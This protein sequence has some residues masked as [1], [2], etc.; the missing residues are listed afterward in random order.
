MILQSINFFILLPQSCN[1][2]I[3]NFEEITL[4]PLSEGIIFFVHRE[5]QMCRH[6]HIKAEPSILDSSGGFRLPNQFLIDIRSFS[7]KKTHHILEKKYVLGAF[8]AS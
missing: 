1:I 5:F 4:Y 7:K 8:G 6:A 3:Y 2:N